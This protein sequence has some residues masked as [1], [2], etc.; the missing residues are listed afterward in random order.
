M[1]RARCGRD[2]SDAEECKVKYRPAFLVL[3]QRYVDCAYA[4]ISGGE[5]AFNEKEC[6]YHAAT[7]GEYLLLAETELKAARLSMFRRTNA[8]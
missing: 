7:A 1:F 5:R 8:A 2:C 4:H 3:A 6:L